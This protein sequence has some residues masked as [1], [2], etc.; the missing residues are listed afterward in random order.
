MR[1]HKDY[2]KNIFEA[3]FFCL[4]A[5]PQKYFLL[6]IEKYNTCYHDDFY[7]HFYG[8]QVFS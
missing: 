3:F 6:K 2:S 8:K 4:Y 5:T 7:F 1:D